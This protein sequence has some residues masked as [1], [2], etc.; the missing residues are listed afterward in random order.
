MAA[1]RAEIGFVSGW[2]GHEWT[3]ENRLELVIKPESQTESTLLRMF[4]QR[5]GLRIEETTGQLTI[6]EPAA[7]HQVDLTCR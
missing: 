7:S 5:M 6:S 1:M 4:A 2:N 3:A